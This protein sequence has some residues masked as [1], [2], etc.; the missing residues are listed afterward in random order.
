MTESYQV[1]VW[2]EVR[3]INF[4][5]FSNKNTVKF[6]VSIE[7]KNK[8][9]KLLI[10]DDNDGDSDDG[11]NDMKTDVRWIL[12]KEH[13]DFENLYKNKI[14]G[15]SSRVFV[16]AALSNSPSLGSLYAASNGYINTL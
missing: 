11:G 6:G 2:I 7:F 5:I 3:E 13:I 10:T 4:L 8:Y 12:D 15:K 1:F 16:S 9:S 14:T